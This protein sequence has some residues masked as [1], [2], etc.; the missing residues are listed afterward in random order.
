ME[1]YRLESVVA[2]FFLLADETFF[3]LSLFRELLAV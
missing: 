1:E 3:P 2:F